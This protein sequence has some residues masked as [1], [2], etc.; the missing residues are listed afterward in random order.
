MV[1][2]SDLSDEA[3]KDYEQLIKVFY[4]RYDLSEEEFRLEFREVVPQESESPQQF[5]VTLDNFP[6]KWME[7]AKVQ[8]TLGD[9]GSAKIGI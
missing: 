3:A 5:L 8:A 1:Y 7:Q 6:M 2:S 4:C 9:L